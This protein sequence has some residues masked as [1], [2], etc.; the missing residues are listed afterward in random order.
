MKLKMRIRLVSVFCIV[1][2]LLTPLSLSASAVV[3]NQS[4]NKIAESLTQKMALGRESETYDVILWLNDIDHDEV[5]QQTEIVKNQVSKLLKN[6]TTR[7]VDLK[8]FTSSG[9]NVRDLDEF[10]TEIEVKRKLHSESYLEHN[11]SVYRKLSADFATKNSNS[12]TGTEWYSAYAPIVKTSLTKNQILS[13]A[14]SSLVDYIYDGETLQI[15]ADPISTTDLSGE[16][17]NTASRSSSPSVWQRTTNADINRDTYG[18]D[19]TGVKVGLLDVGVLRWSEMTSSEKQVFSSIYNAGRLIVDS[20][21]SIGIFPHTVECGSIIV[22]GLSDNKG[23]APGVTLYST[24]VNTTGSD[25]ER[26]FEWLIAQGVNVISASVVY[27]NVSSACTYD[28]VARYIDHIYVHHDTTIVLGSGN[29]NEEYYNTLGTPESSM[30]YNAIVV[31]NSD[32]RETASRADDTYVNSSC[33]STNPLVAAKPDVSAPADYIMSAVGVTGG[34]SMAAPQVAAIVAQLFDQRPSLKTGQTL[35][36]AIIMASIGSY[37][38][39]SQVKS[40]AGTNSPALHPRLGAGIVDAAGVRYIVKNYRYVN[41]TFTSSSSVYTKTFTVS[42][43]DTLMNVAL[44][45]QKN[46]RMTGSHTSYNDPANP[47]CPQLKLEVIAPNGSTFLSAR[48]HGNVQML[49]FVPVGTGTYTIR[50][51]KLSAPASEPTVTFAL[52]WR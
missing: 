17:N 28:Y 39:S 40:V 7:D 29:L 8:K 9:D 26:S 43:S 11:Q 45:W 46:N 6:P 52:A 10:Q 49:T 30:S 15:L 51:T 5:K 4:S 25:L 18:Y 50:V 2:M 37:G 48:T 12:S 33:Y 44:V 34:T 31:G 27:G 22:S 41:T 1:A 20:S 3:E 19:G 21:I 32:D 47:A 16:T 36:K 38:G 13:I 24:S 14:E 23:L 42:S 35:S